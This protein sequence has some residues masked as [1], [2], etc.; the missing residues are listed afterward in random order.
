MRKSK[1]MKIDYNKPIT[2]DNLDLSGYNQKFINADLFLN[3]IKSDT[4]V[5]R[6]LL[7]DPT[8]FCYLMFKVDGSRF[9]LYH[10]QDMIAN[11]QHD[12]VYFRA[13]NQIGKSLLLDALASRNLIIDHGKGHNEAIVSKSLPQAFDQMRRVK[14]L[15][16]SSEVFDWKEE[17]GATDSMSVI[18]FDIKDNN[19]KVKYTNYFICAP[20]T[21]GLLG[22]S[23]HRLNLDE[24]EFWEQDL[25]WFYNQVAQPRTYKT[26]G[27]ITVFSNPNGQD[28]FGAELENQT[29]PDGKTRRFHTYIFTY[30][31]CPGNTQETYDQLKYELPRHE[32]ESTVAGIRS[33]SDR[34]YFTADEIEHSCD[35]KLRELDMVGKQPFFFLDVGAKH[36]KACLIGGYVDYGVNKYSQEEVYLDVA[37]GTKRDYDN[38]FA[39]IYIPIIHLYPQGYPLTRVAGVSTQESDG[40]HHEKSVRE[41]LEEWSKDGVIPVFGY[42]VTG[43]EGMR[44]LF[45]SMNIPAIDVVFSGPSKSGYYQRFKYFMEKGLLH[46][47]RHKEWEKQASELIVTKGT[48]GYLLINAASHAKVGGKSEDAKFKKIPDDCMDATAGF[49]FLA[50]NP[51]VVEPS[52]RRI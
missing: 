42:D 32:F 26:K 33:I 29:L 43:N 16:N 45:Q 13:A 6:K 52:I 8:T 34:N 10:Y 18:S 47:I 15:L 30:L 14:A 9:K 36:D 38:R 41:Y 17:K 23:L 22:Y 39:Q 46:R 4:A 5:Y 51:V 49:I 50:D 3:N 27:T 19:G 21:E 12:R 7:C 31:D 37:T 28:N 2:R 35:K 24:F 1:T 20:C 48:R 25:K 11:D 40:W 44:A